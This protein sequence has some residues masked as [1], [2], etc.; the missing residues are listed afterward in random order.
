MYVE[1][2]GVCNTPGLARDLV[3]PRERKHES[4]PPLLLW[5][6]VIASLDSESKTDRDD[7]SN[8]DQAS[9]DHPGITR[10]NIHVSL[11]QITQLILYNIIHSRS[12]YMNYPQYRKVSGKRKKEKHP[13]GCF[14]FLHGAVLLLG[15][16]CS[17]GWSLS[18]RLRRLHC[19]R[20]LLLRSDCLYLFLFWLL[21]LFV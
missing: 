16:L 2:P 12:I 13:S 18:N 15:F 1:R 9:A 3:V 20:T 19:F 7:E 10:S 6:L 5:R 17:L 14:S 8:Q 21:S 4:A 11:L